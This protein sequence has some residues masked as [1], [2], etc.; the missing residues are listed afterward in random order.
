MLS[1]RRAFF[2]FETL[3]MN[4][5][6]DT[7]QQEYIAKS[8][9][10]RYLE[11]EQRR[12]TWEETVNRYFDFADEHMAAKFPQAFTAWGEAAKII[13]ESVYG[14]KV[15]P[16]M[17]LLMTAGDA[18]RRNHISAFNCHYGAIDKVRR[19]S[20]LLLILMHGTG[21]GFTADFRNTHKLPTIS[22]VMDD[23][24]VT[25][26]VA[27]SK[28]G[29]AKAFKLLLDCLYQGTIPKIDYSKIRAKGKRLKTF[30]GRA[31]GPEPLKKL[32]DY[33]IKVFRNAAGR[34][35]SALEVHD[36]C[37]MV[38]DIVVVGGVRRS[39]LISLSDLSDRMLANAKSN[40]NVDQYALIG[41]DTETVTYTITMKRNQPVQPT[42]RIKLNK[43]KESFIITQLETK[44]I[45]PWYIVEPQR[46]LANNSV[47]YDDRPNV[48]T[49]LK[50]WAAL[51]DSYSGERGFF[52]KKAA[53]NQAEKWGRRTYD[54]DY[55]C[56]PCSEI[57]LRSN[58]FCNLTE[59]IVRADDTLESLKEKVASAT[60]MGIYQ[61]TLTDFKGI[62]PEI[63]KN[64]E[65]ERLLGVSLTGVMDHPVLNQVSQQAIEWLEALRDHA[66]AVATEWAHKLGINV[67]TAITCVKPSGTV[68]QLCN[69]GTGGMHPRFGKYYKRRYRQD[70]KDPITDFLNIQG[71][72]SEPCLSK[73]D[74]QTIFTFVV[75]SPDGAVMRDDRSA[76]EQLEHWLMFQRHWCEHK[77]SITV[78]VKDEEWM[79]VGNWVFNN[80]DEISGVSFLPYDNGSYRQAPFEE[81]TKE[82][83]DE[84]V[85]TYPQSLNWDHF[86][87][88]G[89]QTN[90]S[91]ELA[92]T[93][94]TCGI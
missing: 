66:R 47:S 87:E 78:Y 26:E 58:Q 29:W 33:C 77:P 63:K 14:L 83:Y 70:N 44:K 60:I 8:K 90:G 31:S 23:G 56:N 48:S 71:V 57:L 86:Y 93:G 9:Y 52:N 7:P 13:W 6:F 84:F 11:K 50:E 81:I 53:R 1:I 49:F 3:N 5:V 25:I 67:P 80:F 65:E 28:E 32:F 68:A 4:T 39:A 64:C 62:D 94:N 51:I 43:E 40:F 88:Q 73:P 76:I 42:Y 55:G 36:I 19:F 17:R 15:M 91:Q 79:E 85:K 74:D 27:D 18:V 89:D 75:K 69:T 37:C 34:K 38:A 20:D 92:C 72:H 54:G 10:A 16:S 21:S 61:A 41:E 12:E 59:A 30:G 24:D 46:A 35:L 82:E 45:I 22:D 2:T